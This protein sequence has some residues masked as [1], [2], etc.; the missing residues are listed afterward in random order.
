M[1]RRSVLLTRRATRRFAAVV[2]FATLAGLAPGT[3][4]EAGASG[5]L[6]V[7]ILGDSFSAG[8]GAGNYY[9]VKSCYRSHTTWGELAAT[10][11]GARTG[12]DVEVLNRACSGAVAK[13]I[14]GG[15]TASPEA[16]DRT[17]STD[18]YTRRQIWAGSQSE[19]DG[20]ARDYCAGRSSGDDD[21]YQTGEAV[22]EWSNLYRP[23]CRRK[24]RSQIT[25]VDSSYDL[26]EMT[27]GG[28]DAGF[29]S[30][31][32]DCLVLVKRSADKCDKSLEFAENIVK[33]TDADS[34][35]DRVVRVMNEV[36]RK[37]NPSSRAVPGQVLL[38]AYPYL[39]SNTDY[40]LGSIDV[41]KRLTAVSDRG[42]A[43]QREVMSRYNPTGAGSCVRQQSVFG[44]GTK[45]EFEGHEVSAPINVNGSDDWWLWE[46]V[47]PTATIL[48]PK[49]SGHA[50]EAR[51]AV[52][53]LERAG[54]SGCAT[55]NSFILNRQDNGVE[56]QNLAETLAGIGD[57]VE[58]G[59][60]LPAALDNYGAVWVV[61]A[62]GALTPEEI[63]ALTQ[64]V[65]GGGS[66]YLTGERPCCDALNLSVQS[67][68]NGAIKLPD[69]QI[70]QLGDI[71]GQFAPNFAA[72]G[73]IAVS[74]QRLIDFTPDAPGGMAGLGN[75]TGRNVLVSNGVTPVAG[76]WDETDM[77][78]G[79]GRIVILMDIDWLKESN[80]S[81]YVINVH[82]FLVG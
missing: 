12:A 74:P 71:Y 35:R 63:S 17:L 78:T 20:E 76:V 3:F 49:P 45:A 9:G 42:D 33:R 10:E 80:R 66:L 13:N 36:Q 68:I 67:V 27:V 22:H 51:A 73:G 70:G 40:T 46:V 56:G 4:P 31:G 44:S 15:T 38:L 2:A 23:K 75:V 8:N 6:K 30:I 34:L 18:T 62:Y 28:N 53:A 19:A 50:A 57:V 55:A 41:S 58:R 21:E 65:A 29:S 1:N 82:E 81:Q 32:A 24:V 26:V 14:V 59:S 7:L 72:A 52:D 54:T 60:T 48:H 16:V 79:K 37:L 39:I 69:V 5:N 77:T 43:I 61:M 25:S 47:T 11:L 64:Y